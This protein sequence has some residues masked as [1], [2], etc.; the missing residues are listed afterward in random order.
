MILDLL[1]I[2]MNL[3]LHFG[4][5]F[6]QSDEDISAVFLIFLGVVAISAIAGGI[7]GR[8]LHRN[9]TLRSKRRAS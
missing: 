6:I 9:L 4:K 2:L 7:G 3:V 8:A 1:F 5:G